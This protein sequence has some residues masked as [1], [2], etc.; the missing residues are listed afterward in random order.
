MESRDFVAFLKAMRTNKICS[1]IA[2]ALSSSEM[3]TENI[4]KPR[5][6]EQLDYTCAGMMV[7]GVG[8]R[9]KY[10]RQKFSWV[11]SAQ[12]PRACIA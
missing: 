12:V 11:S 3:I 1:R 4:G 10:I 9:P 8:M 6:S 2:R 7:W 5:G